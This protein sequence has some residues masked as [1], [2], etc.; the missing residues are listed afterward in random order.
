MPEID[1]L[2]VE[3]E[4]IVAAQEAEEWFSRHTRSYLVRKPMQ[5]PKPSGMKPGS[6]GGGGG[7][8]GS[9]AQLPLSQ[10]SNCPQALPQPLQLRGSLRVSVHP[11]S[12][13]ES[14]LQERPQS[15]QFSGSNWR[16]THVELQMDDPAGQ[17][18]K[19]VQISVSG[20][21]RASQEPQWSISNLGT[22]T[23]SHSCWLESS[24]VTRVGSNTHC[25][26]TQLSCPG[27]PGP[28]QRT[29]SGPQA[30]MSSSAT[31]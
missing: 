15:P 29:Q 16:L 12:Q 18:P 22:Q 8:S 25:P 2:E 17:Q 19:K 6:H 24:H 13:Q 5:P 4:Q 11:P 10:I 9:R 26:S 21:Q 20:L 7:G 30:P 28:S 31:H 1:A 27:P 23:P 14:P 3:G